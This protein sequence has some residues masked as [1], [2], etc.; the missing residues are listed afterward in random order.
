MELFHLL[1]GEGK[2]LTLLQMS[3]RGIVVFLI[4]LILIRIS[5]R[6]SFGLNTPFDNIV[7]ILL[8]AI[9]SRAVVG[10]SPFWPVIACC[11]VIVLLHRLLGLL[12]SKSERFSRVIEGNKMLLFEKGRFIENNLK[13]AQVCKEDVMQGLRESAMTDDLEKI[14]RVYIERSGAISVLKKQ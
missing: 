12:V 10:A 5:G 14:D 3:M 13:K 1:F 9:M 11:L 6:R 7:T 2:D 4:A 8:G